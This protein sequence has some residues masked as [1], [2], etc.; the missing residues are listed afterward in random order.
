M[1]SPLELKSV[2][3]DYECR[4]IIRIAER[5][6]FSD[7]ALV[8]GGRDGNIRRARIAWLDSEGDALWVFD[9]VVEAVIAAN[10]SHFGFDLTEFAEKMQVAWYDAGQ[11]GH[12]DWHI[13]AG[14]GQFA[15]KRKLTFV[16]QLSVGR[17]YGGGD[18]E[19]NADG[20]PSAV[21]R[22]LGSAALFPSFTPHRVTPV[23]RG[24]RYSLTA[25]V[26]GPPFR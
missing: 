5:Q 20:R 24:A 21:T 15:Q 9:R 3:E 11:G 26:H 14:A 7:A 8:R 22:R 12:F 4:E 1:L 17:D 10:R 18:L 23:T 25:W 19:L 13:D 6:F 16:L 2:F